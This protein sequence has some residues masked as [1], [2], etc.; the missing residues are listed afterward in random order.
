MVALVAFQNTPSTIGWTLI[1]TKILNIPTPVLPAHVSTPRSIH[2]PG[3]T[4]VPKWLSKWAQELLPTLSRITDQLP[5]NS[6][7]RSLSN[8]LQSHC[9]L[10]TA[11][12][13]PI[14]QEYTTQP[15]M[16]VV[17]I[18]TTQFY[19]SDMVTIKVQAQSTGLFLTP[20]VAGVL[21]HTL[22]L[23][24]ELLEIQIVECAECCATGFRTLRCC[25][26]SS[27]KLTSNRESYG[28]KL[29]SQQQAAPN[30]RSS[31]L[32]RQV[33]NTFLLAKRSYFGLMV[34]THT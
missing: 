7:P 20:G 10:M 5:T 27:V 9:A 25:Q 32:E 15:W 33:L 12:L 19:L 11:I 23:R 14:H 24:L 21:T 17:A 22:N 1:L 8:L 29:E 18:L 6:K 30:S 26:R 13:C 31:L 28:M 4:L 3:M 2:S 34:I 16:I